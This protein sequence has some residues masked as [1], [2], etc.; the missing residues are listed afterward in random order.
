MVWEFHIITT[1]PQFFEPLKNWGVARRA[2]QQGLARL[3]LYNL[4]DFGFGIHRSIDDRPFGGG[5]GMVIRPDVLEACW[6]HIPIEP[7]A[8]K[9]FLT[10]QGQLWRQSLAQEWI[11]QHHQWVI[12]C[13]RYSGVDQRF[14]QEQGF[15][16]VSIG[17]YILSGAEPAAWVLLDTVWRL[18]PHT[19][20]NPE[21]RVFDSFSRDPHLLEGPVYTRPAQWKGHDVAPTLLSGHHENIKIWRFWAMLWWTQKKRPDLWA[22]GNYRKWE[23]WL[24]RWIDA[25]FQS[26]DFIDRLQKLLGNHWSEWLQEVNGFFDPQKPAHK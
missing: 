25:D 20:G 24:N 3:F 12:L 26:H 19:L 23:P 5:D 13:G 8:L 16:E 15:I 4:R 21:S 1:I 2:F 10:P 7:Q 17:D 22:K 11:Q 6:D 18:L 9:I 14:I